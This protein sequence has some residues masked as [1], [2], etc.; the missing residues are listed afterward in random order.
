MSTN[1]REQFRGMP[2]DELQ[3]H[4]NH[5]TWQ[6]SESTRLSYGFPVSI[7]HKAAIVAGKDLS[8]GIPKEQLRK[9]GPFLTAASPESHIGP[10]L[11]AIDFLV[12]DGVQVLATHQG[13]II[14][15][16]QDS[17]EWGD[18]PEFRDKLNYLTIQH[19]S[20]DGSVE[21]SQ[22]CHLAK[23]SV[24]ACGLKIGSTVNAGQVIAIVGKTGWTD[25]DH[26]HFIV[27]RNDGSCGDNPFGFRSLTVKF[28]K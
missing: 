19:T 20:L 12:P 16:V 2:M 6:I 28:Q 24:R 18:G 9:V 17:D 3:K 1:N 22:Y 7:K 21:F 8:K 15:V 11:H 27:F 4:A 23:D 5:L 10:F 25:R 26:L 14:E 13:R